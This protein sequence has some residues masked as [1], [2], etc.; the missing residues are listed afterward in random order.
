VDHLDLESF[1]LLK[2]EV[3]FFFLKF[4]SKFRIMSVR[5]CLKFSVIV[6]MI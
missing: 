2:G 3:F 4:D 6:M 1:R 5:K